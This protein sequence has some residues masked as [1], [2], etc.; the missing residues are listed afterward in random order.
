MKKLLTSVTLISTVLLLNMFGLALHVS[1]MPMASHEM[2]SMNHETSS[3]AT[4][5]TL[6]RTIVFNKDEMVN[7]ELDEENDEPTLPFYARKEVWK[8]SKI[9]VNQKLYADSAKPPP[10]VPIYILYSIFR[11]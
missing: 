10:K 7:L 2:G 1:A 5:V 6:C 4:C 8:F 11:V 3:S 9:H